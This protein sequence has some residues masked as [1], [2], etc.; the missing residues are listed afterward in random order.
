MMPANFA[1]GAA[2]EAALKIGIPAGVLDPG[3]EIP[4]AARDFVD[5]VIG[6]TFFPFEEREVEIA[7]EFLVGVHRENPVVGGG[8]G[9]EVFLLA[10][11]GPVV[12]DEVCAV[13]AGDFFGAVGAAGIDD[14]DFVGDAAERSEGAGEIC[15]FVE[16]DDAGGDAVHWRERRMWR[17]RVSIS[18]SRLCVTA[19]PICW[20]VGLLEPKSLGLESQAEGGFADAE[21]G[22]LAEHGGADALFF[23]EGAIGGV[24]VA[25]VDV[26]FAD[27]DDAMVARDFGVLQGDVGAVAADDDARFFERV[28]GSYAGARDDGEDDVFRLRENGGG[29]LHDE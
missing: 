3:A 18:Q 23:E 9:G 7:A 22:A 13:F 10:V 6:L 5:V 12:D 14:D 29:I 26:V 20:A 15:F 2:I 24:E 17:S 11:V 21:F 19:W 27:F 25:E 8:F 16:S 4:G 28:S 1:D